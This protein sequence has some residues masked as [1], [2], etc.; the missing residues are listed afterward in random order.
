[1]VVSTEHIRPIML[2]DFRK[3]NLREADEDIYD[4][5]EVFCERKK[6]LKIS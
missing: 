3:D 6:L 5:Y 4:S 2:Q 1:M